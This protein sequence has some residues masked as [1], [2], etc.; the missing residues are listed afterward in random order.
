MLLS[1]YANSLAK[2]LNKREHR[3]HLSAEHMLYLAHR[4]LVSLHLENSLAALTSALHQGL[5]GVEFDVQL[6]QDDVPFVFH[7]RH[8]LRLTGVDH[9][10]DQLS[11]SEVARLYQTSDNYCSGYRIASLAE[12]LNHMPPKKL[13]NIELKETTISK[14]L[15]SIAA[16]L[17]V[18]KPHKNKL[19]MIISSFDPA[20]LS[21]VWKLDKSYA[22]GLLLDHKNLW[23]SLLRSL[24][25]I[26]KI[27]FL[28]PH[29]NLLSPQFLNQVNQA[30]LKLILWGH[31]SMGEELSF[32]NQHQGALISDLALELSQLYRR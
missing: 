30:G 18:I 25:I 28:H 5:D 9:Y 14:G 7:D 17:E 26:D 22:L 31:K 6:S 21:L 10:I 24:P 23:I 4:G 1:I 27:D 13:I 2:S 20:I 32:I 19:D 12:V 11:S 29:I 3:L 15:K 16:V 8:L